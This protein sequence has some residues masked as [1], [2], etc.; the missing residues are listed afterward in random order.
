M[1]L[2]IWMSLT[3][4]ATSVPPEESW[5]GVGL[6]GVLKMEVGGYTSSPPQPPPISTRLLGSEPVE[7]FPLALSVPRSELGM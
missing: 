6:G 5:P 3:F 1:L 7:R 2:A 4:R